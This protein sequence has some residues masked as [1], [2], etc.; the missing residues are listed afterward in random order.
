MKVAD[1]IF[2]RI[3]AKEIP[4]QFVY[5]DDDI[6]AFNDIN[7][8][9]PVHVLFIP[10]EHIVSLAGAE[11]RHR[12]LLGRI[13]LAARHV[14]EAHGLAEGY[15]VV[16]NCGAHGGQTV[17]HLHFHLLGGRSMRWPPG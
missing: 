16:N 14:A 8:Q 12:D 7:P 17:H 15:R 3:A 5:E 9:A 11:D 10:R 1:C 2:C 4:G 6:L 13:L